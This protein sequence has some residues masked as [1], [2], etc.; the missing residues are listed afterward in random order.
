[1]S[2][3]VGWFPV[4]VQGSVGVSRLDLGLETSLETHF[5]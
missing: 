3:G 4:F 2:E 5:C 1:M